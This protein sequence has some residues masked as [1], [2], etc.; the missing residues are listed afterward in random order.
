MRDGL[1]A[2]DSEEHINV[3]EKSGFLNKPNSIRILNFIP[4]V[5]I[6]SFKIY[7]YI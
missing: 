6:I 2:R 7:Q 3:K 4:L 5:P 1:N